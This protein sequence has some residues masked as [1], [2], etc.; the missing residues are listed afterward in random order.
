[1]TESR[2][3]KWYWRWVLTGVVTFVPSGVAVY[4]LDPLMV[5]WLY[6]SDWSQTIPFASLELVVKLILEMVLYAPLIVLFLW[7]YHYL[8][9]R[10]FKDGETYC[11]HCRGLLKDLQT[12]RCPTCGEAI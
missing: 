9:F 11:G 3:M 12:P 5:K 8:T 1:M 4:F 2:R 7:T 6:G 10:G